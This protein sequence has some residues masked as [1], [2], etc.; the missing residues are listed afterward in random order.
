M[1]AGEREVEQASKPGRQAGSRHRSD[2]VICLALLHFR[3]TEL[4][5]TNARWSETTLTISSSAIT[6]ETQFIRQF[7]DHE[8]IM[9]NLWEN[10]I[11][12]M[13]RLC[14]WSGCLAIRFIDCFLKASNS[15]FRINRTQSVAFWTTL[16]RFEKSDVLPA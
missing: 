15:M 2:R 9:R 7:L 6:D 5:R 10:L 4:S 3:E 1:E 12:P 11:L 14:R 16:L 8:Q 13:K